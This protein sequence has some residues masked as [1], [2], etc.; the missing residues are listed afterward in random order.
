MLYE[1]VYKLRRQMVRV[2]YHQEST[3]ETQNLDERVLDDEVT[4]KDNDLTALLVLGIV[5]VIGALYYGWDQMT[6][7]ENEVVV[8]PVVVPHDP[9]R[10]LGEEV[11]DAEIEK[12]FTERPDLWTEKDIQVLVV[13]PTA[14]SVPLIMFDPSS[15]TQ[16][17]DDTVV[18]SPPQL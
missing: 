1:S 14:T 6:Q 9:L 2:C 4:K 17:I 10:Q 11:T 13:E 16:K 3:M 7:K 8:S 5:L 12:L 18:I 15:T